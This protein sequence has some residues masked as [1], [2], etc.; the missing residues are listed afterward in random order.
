[1]TI[2]SSGVQSGPGQ[3]FIVSAAATRMSGMSL[4]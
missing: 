3:T 1:M 2:L 4:I